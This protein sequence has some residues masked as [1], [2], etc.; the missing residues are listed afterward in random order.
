MD[1]I[2]FPFQVTL[3]H[4]VSHVQDKRFQHVRD[5]FGEG[6]FCIKGSGASQSTLQR[7]VEPIIRNVS[8]RHL[9]SDRK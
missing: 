9:V 3:Q 4:N 2:S 8:S 5:W 7:Q 1:A 6:N